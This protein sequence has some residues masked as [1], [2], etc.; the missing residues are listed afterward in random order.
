MKR[1]VIALATILSAAFASSSMAYDGTITF[2]GKVVA[3]TC[4][5]N[6]NDKNLAVTLPTVSTTTLNENAA[7]AGLTP[8]TIHLTGCAIGMDGAQSVKTYF[9]PSSDIDVTTHN[10]K[11]TAQTKADNVQVQL[12]NSDAATTI[13]LGT[14]SA[15]QDVHPVQ[16]DNANVNLPY[17]AQYYA[18]G[19]STAGDVKATVH[20]TIA[21]E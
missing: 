2:T 1:K 14:D 19:Q 20:Y 21:Y 11:N 7:T 15:T 5:V 3:Q 13:Q 10:L 8:F 6:T 16:I 9:E 12:L 4:S 17:F 18:T